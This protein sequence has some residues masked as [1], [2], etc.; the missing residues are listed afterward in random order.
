MS[1][2]GDIE[3]ALEVLT[4]A[5]TQLDLITVLQCNTEYPTP[6]VDV[7]LRAMESIRNAFGV[8]V[9]FSDHTEGIE[10]VIA[11][12]AMGA[13]VIEKHFTV[14]RSLPGPDHLA[15]L[16]PR[17]FRSMVVAVRNIELAL[18]DGRKRPT[19]SEKKNMP[20]AR[21]SIV[22]GCVIQA[23]E[24]FAEHNLT[25]KRPGEGVSP[26]RWDEVI[27]TLAARRFEPDELIVI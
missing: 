27:G 19:P 16:E 26:M 4:D 10:A 5:G 3:A 12:V 15:S 21:K 25:V 22:A 8:S 14:D 11:A 17:E 20:I 18:G 13:T 7:N 2:L 23:G 24:M 9:G 1:N 6:M